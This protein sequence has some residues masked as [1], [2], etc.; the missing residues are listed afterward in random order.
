[1]SASRIACA[2]ACETLQPRKRTENVAIG[3]KML[4]AREEIGRPLLPGTPGEVAVARERR[5]LGL[6]VAGGDR[7]PA[8]ESGRESLQSRSIE[9][10]EHDVGFRQHVHQRV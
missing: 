10:R 6:V 9:V 8:L 3:A 7:Q 4:L 1:M 5:R 2:S